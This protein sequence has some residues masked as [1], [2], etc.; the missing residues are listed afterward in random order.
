MSIDVT[1]LTTSLPAQEEGIEVKLHDDDG[2]EI[3]VTIRVAGPDA[4][5]VKKARAHLIE[6]RVQ[7]RIRKVTADRMEYEARYL[8][9]ACCISWDG[10]TNG[11]EPY[12]CNIPNAMK[13]FEAKPGWQE[14]VDAVASNRTVF[15]KA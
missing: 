9:A 1:K 7:L 13:L 3:G 10:L 14:E 11:A 2:E 12:E 6:E 5:R 15:P 4:R 8:A